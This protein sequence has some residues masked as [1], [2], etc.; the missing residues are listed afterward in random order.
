MVDGGGGAVVIVQVWWQVGGG[1]GGCRCGVMAG[2][3]WWMVLVFLYIFN[4]LIKLP[5][6]PYVG[7]P[8]SNLTM[9]NN[10]VRAKGHNV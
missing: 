9:K 4:K 1:V 5:K 7:Y 8:W 10:R 6:Y 2:G 3:C